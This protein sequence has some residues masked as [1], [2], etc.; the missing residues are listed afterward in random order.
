MRILALKPKGRVLPHI[1]EAMVKAFRNLGVEVDNVPMPDKD[2]EFFSIKD[3][4]KSN[5]QAIF[6]IN[7]GGDENFLWR[8]IE[9][10]IKYHHLWIVWFVDDPEG[11][12]FPQAYAPS[13]TLAFC[14]D[15]GIVKEMAHISSEGG[16]YL[17]YLPLATNPEIFFPENNIPHCPWRGIFVGAVSHPNKLLAEIIST[18]SDLQ[19]EVKIYGKFIGKTSQFRSTI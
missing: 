5:Y 12:N 13:Y 7:M 16:G 19:T 15:R 8:I 3:K 18:N 14:W 9:W 17:H 4:L 11:Y 6:A 2:T 1:H 10:Q